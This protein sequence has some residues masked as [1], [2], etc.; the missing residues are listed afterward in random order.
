[1]NFDPKFAFD[2]LLP[3]SSAA[4]SLPLTKGIIPTGYEQ[5][6]PIL[7][8]GKKISKEPRFKR[9]IKQDQYGWVYW[10]KSNGILIV[11]YRGTDDLV[12]AIKDATIDTEPYKCVVNYG[13][14]HAG[15]QSVYFA[16]RD[17]VIAACRPLKSQINQVILTGHSM[18]AAISELSA[19]DLYY[20]HL[21]VPTVINFAAPRVGKA[22]FVE[23]FDRD[24]PDCLRIVNR[25]DTVPHLP[26]A[27]HGYKHVGESV[28]IN[29]GFTLNAL[30]AHALDISYRMGLSKLQ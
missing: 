7:V 9:L 11:A 8:D 30:K 29:G 18:G 12:D 4:Y 2:T 27:W 24:I 17:S 21:G 1:M 14:V 25:W 3:L 15:F 20:Q 16:I 6:A 22:D 13:Q 19:P 23:K 10:N 26:S 28:T 5:I